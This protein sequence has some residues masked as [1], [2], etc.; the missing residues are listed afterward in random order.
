MV[1]TAGGSLYAL[2][3]SSADAGNSFAA[4]LLA[5]SPVAGGIV[6]VGLSCYAIPC[7]WSSTLSSDAARISR[8]KKHPGSSVYGKADVRITRHGVHRVKIRLSAAAIK[9]LKAKGKLTV[10][11]NESTAIGQYS[12]FSEHKTVRLTLKYHRA[13]KRRG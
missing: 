6:T 9:T 8:A 12:A 2:E 11:L 7:A 3:F 13:R 5:A 10:F 1:I 4:Q